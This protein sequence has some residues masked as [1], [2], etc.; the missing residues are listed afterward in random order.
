[1][2]YS[3]AWL[4]RNLKEKNETKKKVRFRSNLKF[5]KPAM[6][7]MICT[8]ECD[9]FF[10]H[11]EHVDWNSRISYHITNNDTGTDINKMVQGSSASMSAMTE[12]KLHMKVHQVNS[13][14]RSHVL[15]STKY[16]TKA[17]AKCFLLT[18]KLSQGSKISTDCKNNIIVHSMSGN[19]IMTAKSW[20]TIVR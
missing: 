3:Y 8:I 19:I 10:I 15:W 14:E 12:S 9:F 4:L 18:W 16:C 2:M 20:L 6:A 5:E 1:M 13:N 17:G 11:K 7:G